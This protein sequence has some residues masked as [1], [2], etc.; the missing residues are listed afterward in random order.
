MNAVPQKKPNKDEITCKKCVTCKIVRTPRVY[1]CS[2]C[3]CCISVHDHHCPWV[4]NCIGQRNH[5][6]FVIYNWVTEALSVYTA[7]LDIH[8]AVNANIFFKI[9]DEFFTSFWL[10]IILIGLYGIIVALLLIGLS[11][12]HSCLACKNQTTSEELKEKYDMWGGNPY[13][14]GDFSLKN[15]LY[16]LHTQESLVF[17][18]KSLEI[19]QAVER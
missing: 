14:Y 13:S 18:Q 2:I 11:I 6:S 12:Y 9:D 3:D 19:H 7:A 10:P 16:F 5:K 4:G 15:C 17:G 1:H 8:F